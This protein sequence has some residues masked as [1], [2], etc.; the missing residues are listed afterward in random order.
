MRGAQRH[1]GTEHSGERQRLV[2][3]LF[4]AWSSQAVSEEYQDYYLLFLETVPVELLETVISREVRDTLEHTS[5]YFKMEAAGKEHNKALAR[6]QELLRR[7]SSVP[8][9]SESVL[10]VLCEGVGEVR[11]SSVAV[12][13]VVVA[14]KM[15]CLRYRKEETLIVGFNKVL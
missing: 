11:N 6:L 9:I 14:L 7:Y 1:W 15:H 4:K 3:E 12:A 2:K 5:Y 10:E 8:K 13:E